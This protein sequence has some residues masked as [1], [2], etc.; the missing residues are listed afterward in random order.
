MHVL[1]AYIKLKIDEIVHWVKVE[2]DLI[3]KANLRTFL[4]Q[5]MIVK[6]Q[7]VMV[8]MMLMLTMMLLT[9]MLI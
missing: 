2:L 7:K 5:K 8:V 1:I 3:C 6:Q 4:Q 9:M